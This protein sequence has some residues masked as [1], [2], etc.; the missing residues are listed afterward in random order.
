MKSTNM[1][2][3]YTVYTYFIED[4]IHAIPDFQCAMKNLLIKV[5][6][7]ILSLVVILSFSRCEGEN[8][9]KEALHLL[10]VIDERN[11]TLQMDSID[12]ECKK[13]CL[14]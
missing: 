1:N 6:R 2:I 7:P 10:Q 4:H 5:S 3:S 14:I 12:N 9:D 11:F 8:F 13:R